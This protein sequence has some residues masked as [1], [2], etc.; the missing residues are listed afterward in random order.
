MVRKWAHGLQPQTPVN[1]VDLTVNPCTGLDIC[2]PK[3]SLTGVRR[4]ALGP[5]E[6]LFDGAFPRPSFQFEQQTVLH[7]T[8]WAQTKPEGNVSGPLCTQ[9]LSFSSAH[10][11]PGKGNP[12]PPREGV[13][14][15]LR[16]ICFCWSSPSK[17]ALLQSFLQTFSSQYNPCLLRW[18]CF[19]LD[20]SSCQSVFGMPG[21][22]RSMSANLQATKALQRGSVVHGTGKSSH[23]REFQH[24][25]R[26]S[27]T[28]DL[29][30]KNTLHMSK[31]THAIPAMRLPCLWRNTYVILA[32]RMFCM[33]VNCKYTWSPS[34]DHMAY[35]WIHIHTCFASQNSLSE[36][37]IPHM[38]RLLIV[39]VDRVRDADKSIYLTILR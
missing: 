19:I 30:Q 5:A 20:I 2:S 33:C 10:C 38:Y 6:G 14:L 34:W 1:L 16:V 23:M 39:L 37:S 9:P 4:A 12:Y 3:C 7:Q 15:I 28:W 29:F 17:T 22:Y 8:A 24:M 31:H 26:H 32:M 25:Y 35:V 13:Y 27:Q 21:D 18:V 36:A 11:S